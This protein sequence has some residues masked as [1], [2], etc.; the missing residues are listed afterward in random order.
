M[1]GRK[2]ERL[3]IEYLPGNLFKNRAWH[4][5]EVLASGTGQLA[6]FV[7]GGNIALD[8]D[9]F[10][11]RQNGGRTTAAVAELRHF[12]VFADDFLDL[13]GVLVLDV[14][15][16]FSLNQNCGFWFTSG[17]GGRRV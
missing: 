3:R 2:Q 13:H 11:V 17:A 15:F 1:I 9:A 8:E 12:P 6:A 14:L 10:P 4:F 16:D 7:D 5:H